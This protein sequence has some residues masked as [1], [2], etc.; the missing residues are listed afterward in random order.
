MANYCIICGSELILEGNNML[1]DLVWDIKDDKED[2]MVTYAHCPKCH[3]QYE[4]TDATEYE[5]E[6]NSLYVGSVRIYNEE[7]ENDTKE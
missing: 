1:S 5:Q 4:M 3:C 2:A 7:K 6:E